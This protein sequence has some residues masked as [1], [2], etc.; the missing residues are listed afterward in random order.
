MGTRRAIGRAL[1]ASVARE[2]VTERFAAAVSSARPEDLS[3]IAYEAERHGVPGYVA[4][5]DGWAGGLLP[6]E[7]AEDVSA[8]GR[9]AV[10]AHLAALADL[11]QVA[12][13]FAR[14]DVRWLIVKG[15]V[16]AEMLHG[17]PE[18]RSYSDVDLLVDPARLDA[19]LRAL[20]DIDGDVLDRNWTLLLREMK[21]ELHV[22][23]PA[24]TM[25]DLHWD[26]FNARARRARHSVPFDRLHA[27]SVETSVGRTKVRTL[28]P[29]DTLVYVALHTMASGADRLV[30]I[31]DLDLA[32]S[33]AMPWASDLP[34][35]IEEWG[36]ELIVP[37]ALSRVD[38]ALGRRER[39]LLTRGE[40]VGDKAWMWL[41]RAAWKASPVEQQNGEASLGRLIA[42]S[43][44]H[45]AASSMRALAHKSRMLA[46][47]GPKSY[48]ER[49]LGA[50]HPGSVLYPGGGE[51]QRQAFLQAVGQGGT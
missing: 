51:A 2:H 26:L 48:D 46:K 27:R 23:M 4:R 30:W 44:R 36:A 39:T 8:A 43:V 50:A 33:A 6:P 24:G 14:A 15:P 29:L 41:C 9:T 37:A 22:E 35:R 7:E 45:D 16:L 3:G 10:F 11:E 1:R 5:A 28:D 34:A 12:A 20:D 42:R 18:L 49:R 17:R 21:G 38:A 19:A 25:I 31:K 40:R 32:A 13:A 47:E